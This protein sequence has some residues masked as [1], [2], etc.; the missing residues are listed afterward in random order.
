MTSTPNARSEATFEGTRRAL[1]RVAAHVLGRRR[2]D[3]CGR[4]G[5]R[6]SPGGFATPMFGDG[7]ETVRIAGLVLMREIAGTST[8]IPLEGSTLRG[9]ARF[10]EADVDASFTCGDDG[11]QLGDPDE[12]LDLDARHART[13]ADWFELSWRVLD[14]TIATLPV[15]AAPATIQ[16]WPEHFDAGTNVEVGN[17]ERV[18]LGFSP[19]D[20]YEPLPYLYV[21][22]WSAERRGDSDFWNASFGATLPAKA[23]FTSP[24]AVRAGTAF[25][26]AGLTNAS[27]K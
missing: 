4:F 10:V 24:D 9:L 23:L 17:G 13:I 5:L 1:Q 2:F 25:L 14:E 27:A 22:P 15:S 3:V 6:A 21:G 7:L 12:L 20:A 16:L 18:N 11:P 19:G 26:L 8:H